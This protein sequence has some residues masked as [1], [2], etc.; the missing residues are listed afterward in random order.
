MSSA[1]LKPLKDALDSAYRSCQLVLS[2]LAQD[3]N[4]LLPAVALP[5]DVFVDIASFLDS[6]SIVNLSAACHRWR[7]ATIY[8]QSLDS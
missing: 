5:D 8:S 1:A 7:N 3:L 2:S 4:G 6:T